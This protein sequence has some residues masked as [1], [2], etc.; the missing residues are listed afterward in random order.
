VPPAWIEEEP[1]TIRG[2]RRAQ[3]IADRLMP[4]KLSDQPKGGGE[5]NAELTFIALICGGVDSKHGHLTISRHITL[6][7]RRPHRRAEALCSDGELPEI[8]LAK[9][10]CTR[11][12]SVSLS[13]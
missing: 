4:A 5:V 3:M 2:E 6:R 8:S 12:R 9:V 11:L 1:P 10:T 7:R 13:N